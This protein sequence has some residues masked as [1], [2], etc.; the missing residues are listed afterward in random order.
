MKLN[1]K[2]NKP[3]KE[4]LARLKAAGF[5]AEP[6]TD[7]RAGGNTG[8][9]NQR[10][11]SANGSTFAPPR[12]VKVEGI[13]YSLNA[14]ENILNAKTKIEAGTAKEHNAFAIHQAKVQANKSNGA[15]RAPAMDF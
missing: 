6:N 12:L 7:H 15:K 4:L 2:V 3:T 8:A 11:H 5:D 10:R 14:A 9:H 13:R 1:Q